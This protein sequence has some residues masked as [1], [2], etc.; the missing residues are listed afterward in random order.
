[1]YVYIKAKVCMF[2]SK[3]MLSQRMWTHDLRLGNGN[4]SSVFE[5]MWRKNWTGGKTETLVLARVTGFVSEKVTQYV[6]KPIFVKIN[7]LLVHMYIGKK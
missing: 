1:M 2:T 4:Q 6:A 5:K 3:L 7:I